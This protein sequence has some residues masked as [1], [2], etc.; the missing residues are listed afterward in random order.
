MVMMT[1]ATDKSLIVSHILMWRAKRVYRGLT[2]WSLTAEE[3]D[4]TKVVQTSP[5]AMWRH[6]D[7]WKESQ[8][9]CCQRSLSVSS[10][11]CDRMPREVYLSAPVMWVVVAFG[12]QQGWIRK[13]RDV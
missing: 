12:G 9:Y 1:A 7:N 4:R 11:R 6:G 13:F 10:T 3:R 5:T 2:W 8:E